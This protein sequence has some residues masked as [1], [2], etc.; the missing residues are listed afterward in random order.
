MTHGNAATVVSERAGAGESHTPSRDVKS[1]AHPG[2]WPGKLDF[3][4]SS[5][6][7]SS[8]IQ[9]EQVFSILEGNWA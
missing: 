9:S 4:F 6:S 1:T 3:Q 5:F 7:A 2:P 8:G